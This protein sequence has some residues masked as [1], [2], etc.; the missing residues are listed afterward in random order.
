MLEVLIQFWDRIVYSHM[1]MHIDKATIG[2][3]C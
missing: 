3:I 1:I 2:F